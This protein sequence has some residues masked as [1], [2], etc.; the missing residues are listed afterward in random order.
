[1]AFE[2]RVV[3]VDVE[4]T[5]T[6]HARGDRVCEIGLVVVEG[7]RI[8]D[9]YETLLNPEREILS[10]FTEVHGISRATVRK[11]PKFIDVLPTVLD[12]LEGALVVAH[13]A[14]FDHGFID[15]EVYLSSGRGLPIR[16]ICTMRWAWA[17]WGRSEGTVE[18][19]LERL[20]IQNRCPHHALPDAEA[21]TQVLLEFLGPGGVTLEN[22]ARA[23]EEGRIAKYGTGRLPVRGAIAVPPFARIHDQIGL[24]PQGR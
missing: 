14:T 20:H 16:G 6:S 19:V 21:E 13:N 10:R 11:A 12:Y 15:N 4:T 5:G 3:V 17:K 2:P 9:R 23:E 8:V 7:M 18:S 24:I 22:I 1:M